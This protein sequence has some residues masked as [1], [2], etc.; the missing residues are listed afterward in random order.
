MGI[1]IK[2]GKINGNLQDILIKNGIIESIGSDIKNDDEMLYHGEGNIIIPGF[3]DCHAHLDKSLLNDRSPYIDV[4]GPEKGALTRKEKEKFTK[5]DIKDRAKRVLQ[6]MSSFGTLAVRT[7]VDVDPIVGLKGVEALLELKKEFENIIKVQIVAFAQEGF[8]KYPDTENLLKEAMNMGCDAVGGHTI[9]DTDG[10]A[11][12]DKVF[13]IAKRFNVS[14]DF[15]ADESGN[16]QHYLLPYLADKTIAE[17][18][19]GKVNAIHACSLSSIDYNEALR[20]IEKM[21]EADIRVIVAPTAIS[22]RKLTLVKELLKVGVI[23]GLGS[24]NIQDFFNPLG[25][26]NLLHVA[27]L[28][29]YDRRFFAKDEQ[30]QIWKMITEDGAKILGLDYG[31]SQNLEA[32]LTMLEGKTIKDVMVEMKPVKNIIRGNNII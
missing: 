19:V 20:T 10:K 30:L 22:T 28:L 12:I 3:I 25:C 13:E 7:N 31:V 9:V 18:Y 14:M 32:N 15:H 2:N 6:K 5:E 17:G 29:A 8:T 21:K 16:P 1:L 26:G 23:I 24:D 27:M 4:T 11:H